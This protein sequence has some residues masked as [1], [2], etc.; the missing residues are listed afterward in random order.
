MYDCILWWVYNDFPNVILASICFSATDKGKITYR[1]CGP[2]ADRKYKYTTNSCSEKYAPLERGDVICYCDADLCND[3]NI[4]WNIWT[5]K[6]KC[7]VNNIYSWFL[8]WWLYLIHCKDLT[9]N[10]ALIAQLAEQLMLNQYWTK[11]I[12]ELIS[13]D[14]EEQKQ[15]HNIS[16]IFKYFILIFSYKEIKVDDVLH[17]IRDHHCGPPFNKRF[18]YTFGCDVT[19][20]TRGVKDIK[21]VLNIN[22]LLFVL[23]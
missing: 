16:S 5:D 17:F 4:F 23:V 2:I 3:W 19:T 9:A 14:V 8:L 12:V 13:L 6:S 1:S 15:V 18:S 7:I 21:D 11:F 22:P 10:Q 20:N